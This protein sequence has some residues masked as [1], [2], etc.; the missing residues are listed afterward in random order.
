MAFGIFFV[1]FLTFLA[2]IIYYLKRRLRKRQENLI[3]R[4][5]VAGAMIFVSPNQK[6]IES[7]EE[8]YE[9]PPDIIEMIF[10]AN[11]FPSKDDWQILR[12]F[13]ELH[14]LNFLS[15]KLCDR[16]FFSILNIRGTKIKRIG[17]N[18]ENMITGINIPVLN[19]LPDLEELY[20]I[21]CPQLKGKYFRNLPSFSLYGLMIVGCPITDEHLLD[22]PILRGLDW[23]TLEEL[24]ITDSIS[25]FFEDHCPNLTQI[26]VAKTKCTGKIIRKLR[27]PRQ[28]TSL[29]LS[30]LDVTDEDMKHLRRFI[31]LTTLTLENTGITDASL[32]ILIGLPFLMTCHVE[33][34]KLSDEGKEQLKKYLDKSKKQAELINFSS[35]AKEDEHQD[36]FDHI[37]SF[38]QDNDTTPTSTPSGQTKERI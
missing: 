9:T 11:I 24:D 7:W 33:G 25:L 19:R 2:S 31:G 6:E 36:E 10:I 23:I 22:F 27:H 8:L 15:T 20:F 30:D 18:N 34:T 1:T 38:D 28:I 26:S 13:P 3:D 5:F 12:T 35:N 14:F 21:N 37:I 17:F 16:D 4:I 29:N 32:P